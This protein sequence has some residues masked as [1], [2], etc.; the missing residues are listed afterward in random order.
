MEESGTDEAHCS[1][2]VAS[3]RR[4]ASAIRSLANARNFQLECATV[5]YESLL[6]PVLTYDSET[7]VWREK[8]K[9]ILRAAQMNN[10]RG[11][12]GIRRMNKSPGR[13]NKAVVR[14]DERCGRKD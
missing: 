6:V 2:K 14:S 7:L 9:F 4:V 1:S 8:E 3:G 5:L 12:L 13:T 10:L 11:L